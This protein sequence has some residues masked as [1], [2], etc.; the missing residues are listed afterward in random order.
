LS[1]TALLLGLLLVLPVDKFKA[2]KFLP[3]LRM[4]ALHLH[5][6]WMVAL[7]PKHSSVFDRAGTCLTFM[8]AGSAAA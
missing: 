3:V 1:K 7:S 2:L 6:I 5:G 8:D 4:A